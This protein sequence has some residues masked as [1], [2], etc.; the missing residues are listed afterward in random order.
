MK[1]VLLSVLLLLTNAA[2]AGGRKGVS[3][4]REFALKVGQSALIRPGGMKITFESVL[5]DSRCPEGVN[6]IWAG[7]ARITVGL[8]GA[9]GRPTPL[10]LNTDVEPRQQSYLDYEVKLMGLS[11]R[12]KEGRSVDKNSYTVTLLV[13][14]K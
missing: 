13:K 9:G 5:E 7:N 2:Q 1:S 10:E 4:N 14:K 11:P 3:L 8:S 12:P 6:C